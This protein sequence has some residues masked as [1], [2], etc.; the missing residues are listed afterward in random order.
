MTNDDERVAYLAGD[1]GAAVDDLT[2]A[3]LDELTALLGDEAVWSQP[4][5]ELEGAVV[6]A[7]AAEA[8]AAPGGRA[9]AVVAASPRRS[10]RT[11]L[12]SWG[13][14]RVVLT[15]AAGVVALAVAGLVLTRAGNARETFQGAFED[16]GGTVELSRFDSG[17]RVELDAPG[18]P[19]R[20]GGEFY[21]AWLRNDAGVLVSIG[22]FNEGDD[23]VLWAG[24]PP[25]EFRTITVTRESADG[26]PASSGDR[27]LVGTIDVD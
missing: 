26:D 1:D 4:P 10:K 8:A 23:V 25:S 21:E 7:I 16:D 17:W 11:T 14:A 27:A 9:P 18:L 15:A 20:D 2:R 24:V 5:A 19:R 22:T 13:V 6:A 3:D 12:R